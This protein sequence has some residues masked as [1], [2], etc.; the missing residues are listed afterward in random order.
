MK[1]PLLSVIT[2]SYNAAAV[3]ETTIKSVIE[4]QCDDFEYIIIDGNST[5]GTQKIVEK[6]RANL[7]VWISEPDK[8]IAD[9]LNKA[10]SHA[11]GKYIVSILAGDVLLDL[12]YTK[13][14]NE[15]AD[16]VCF[17]VLVTG[18]IIKYPYVNNWLKVMN[19]IPHQGAF[20]KNTV[21][22]IHDTRYRYYCDLDL[23]QKYYINKLKVNVYNAPLVAFHGLDGATSNK[24]N[25]KE[26]FTIVKNNYGSAYEAFSYVYFKF[27]G[28]RKRLGFITE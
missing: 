6:Y 20:F 21:N 10:V 7:A 12:P 28:L 22:L 15:D 17:P 13:L 18:D 26:V 3:I 1:N 4:Q 9:A 14:I 2:V 11:R 23:C 8:G 16:L 24:K 25:F 27:L 19:T 5:D